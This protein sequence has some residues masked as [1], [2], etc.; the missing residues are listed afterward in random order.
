MQNGTAGLPK[1]CKWRA[2]NITRCMFPQY[3]A[4]EIETQ[5]FPIQSLYDPLQKG[6]DPQSHGD[7]LLHQI[8]DT[9]LQKPKNGG[10]LHSCERCV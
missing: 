9:V 4:D 1:N 10:W 6:R 8:T 5:L 3:F 7:W 2:K